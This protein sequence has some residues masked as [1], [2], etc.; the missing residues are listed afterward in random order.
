MSAFRASVISAAWPRVDVTVL[1]SPHAPKTGVYATRRGS[2][3][4]FGIRGSEAEIPTDPELAEELRAA[5]GADVI[6]EPLDHGIVVPLL[7]RP[8]SA[9]V[10]ACG[11]A[12]VTGPGGCHPSD[13]L[14]DARSLAEAVG[15]FASAHRVLFVANAHSS[16]ALSSRA[17]LMTRSEGTRLHDLLFDAAKRGTVGDLAEVTAADWHAAG[18]CGVGP[19]V[20]LAHL[21]PKAVVTG[22][23]DC[24]PFGV[25]YLSVTFDP[26]GAE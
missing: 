6:D 18:A 10:V 4:G 8:F 24:S 16:A 26:V 14:A 25:G 21:L 22:F 12:E 13:V 23:H 1:V 17:P 9:P 19:L 3:D 2:L 20:A 5:W 7:L 11:F 15:A